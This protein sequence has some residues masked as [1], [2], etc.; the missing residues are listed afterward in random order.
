MRKDILKCEQKISEL[1]ANKHIIKITNKIYDLEM[2]LIYDMSTINAIIKLFCINT[3]PQLKYTPFIDYAYFNTNNVNDWLSQE[4][5]LLKKLDELQSIVEHVE[6][7][8]YKFDSILI[9][10]HVKR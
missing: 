9:P 7:Y 10:F 8:I 5:I 3:L 6:L 4:D 1:K 2:N